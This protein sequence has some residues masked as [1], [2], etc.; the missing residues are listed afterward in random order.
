MPYDRGKEARE[1]V[2]S[3][4]QRD[5]L[6]AQRDALA[7]ACEGAQDSLVLVLELLKGTMAHDVVRGGFVGVSKQI[8]DALAL[9]RE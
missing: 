5:A 1:I 9:V 3:V 4:N 7:G 2:A 6:L 8:A